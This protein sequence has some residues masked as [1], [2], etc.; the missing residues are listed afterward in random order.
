MD[1]PVV[2]DGH[3]SAFEKFSLQVQSLVGMLRTLGQEGSVELQCR[4]HVAR[5]LNKLLPN[6][7]A[8]FRRHLLHHANTEYTLEGLA[9]WLKHEAW[10]Q[11]YES[12]HTTVLQG[13][14]RHKHTTATVL[15]GVENEK[16][17]ASTNAGALPKSRPK[18][19]CFYCQS[20]EHPFSQCPAF[21]TLTKDQPWRRYQVSQAF[22]AS[23]LALVD[24]AY[25][26]SKLPPLIR[27]QDCTRSRQYH[28]AIEMLETKTVCI[29]VEGMYRY[30]T[31]LL[32]KQDIPLLCF[33]EAA[34]LPRLRSL[35][36]KLAKD[37]QSAAAYRAEIQKLL[38]SGSVM[39]LKERPPNEREL[40][41]IP[42]HMVSHN[43]K[44]RIVFDC[45]FQSGGISLNDALLPGPSLGSSLLGVLLRFREHAVAISGDV[46]AMFHQ[47]RL[48]SE[49]SPLLRFIWR[50]L[51]REDP[52]DIYEWRVLPF[53]TTCSP[54]C[55]IYALQRH[56]RQNSQP[57]EDVRLSVERNFYVDNCLQ[58][59]PSAEE[60]RKLIDKLRALLARGGFEL[61][62][63]SSN[64]QSVTSHQLKLGQA[65]VNS[66]WL[67][68]RL[69]QER[70]P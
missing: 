46:Q 49:D 6:R 59:L 37:P 64:V 48:L 18:S 28:D 4:S 30:A 43:T 27:E 50:D 12:E 14:Q 60:A 57:G 66:G 23:W 24:H 13:I 62:Q 20:T 5:L 53:G 55:P 56:V 40:W 38:L 70:E 44:N 47:V 11:E 54:C 8:D 51:R 19:H 35:E 29:E 31:P 15:I 2:Q 25:P 21:Q 52:P 42:H 10:C 58:S 16:S 1:L 63:W 3:P 69:N 39:K 26:V 36:V 9:G 61:R 32:H 68:R 22:T 67:M 45:S 33:S 17:Q 34:V 41:F 65:A 7:R